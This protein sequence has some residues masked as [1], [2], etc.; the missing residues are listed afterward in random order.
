MPSQVTIIKL[1][2]LVPSEERGASLCVELDLELHKTKNFLCLSST[3]LCVNFI[4][5]LLECQVPTGSPRLTSCCF[6]V[7][8]F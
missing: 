4:A 5:D 8:N 7:F 2:G 6:V 3:S 1:T